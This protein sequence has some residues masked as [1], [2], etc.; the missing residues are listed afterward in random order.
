MNDPS[1]P[2]WTDL[3]DITIEGVWEWSGGNADLVAPAGWPNLPHID[4]YTPWESMMPTINNTLNCAIGSM[5]KQ[6]S[7]E[8]CD[9][10][11]VVQSQY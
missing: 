10:K 11:V 5:S 3:S 7:E 1:Y 4:I 6:Y 9:E 2:F 8:N